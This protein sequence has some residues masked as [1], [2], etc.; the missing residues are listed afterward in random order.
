M[1]FTVLDWRLEQQNEQD[2]RTL[3][4]KLQVD[5]NENNLKDAQIMFSGSLITELKDGITAQYN[6]SEFNFQMA[7]LGIAHLN[8]ELT[9]NKSA[10]NQD[11]FSYS[12]FTEDYPHGSVNIPDIKSLKNYSFEI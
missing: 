5:N 2:I 9:I 1:K 6:S 3:T 10:V 12:Y 7:A 11:S 4:Y 8:N